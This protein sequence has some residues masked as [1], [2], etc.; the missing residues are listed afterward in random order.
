MSNILVELSNAMADAAEKAG[1][2][3]VMVDAR[4]RLPASGITI[5]P[6]LVL[7]AS[8]VVEREDDIFVQL[9]DG[10]RLAA[11]LAGRDLG[12]DLAV[13]R[14]E[15]AA[16]KPAE[17]A[18]EAKIGQLVLALGRPS[19]EGIEAS[20]GVISA[21]GG[22]VRTQRGSLD[23]Y[24]RTDAIPYPGF[25]GGPLVDAEG[26]LVG[27][28]TSGFGPGA[29][30]TI[31]AE[32]ALKIAAQLIEHGSVKRGHLGIRSQ[33]VA[34][35]GSAQKALNREQ[36]VGLLVISVESGSPAE[37]GGLMVG[38]ILVSLDG[39]PLADHEDLFARLTGAVVGKTL[40]VEIVRGGQ[41]AT[42]QVKVGARP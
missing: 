39:S 7:T 1:T 20:L 8:H 32:N 35:P 37:A 27:L 5:A 14:L 38:D 21:V 25:S 4:K 31:P 28:N 9:S 41:P 40:P 6:D 18:S 34:V 19:Q 15:R 16:A 11:T 12:T 22:P 42:L 29:V 10:S 26:K 3:T 17:T 24:I 30:L 23:K 36:A 13:L 33:L 2:Y